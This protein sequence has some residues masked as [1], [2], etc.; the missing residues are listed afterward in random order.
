LTASSFESRLAEVLG[1]SS[2]EALHA[3]LGAAFEGGEKQ[4]G[5]ARQ[6]LD[7]LFGTAAEGASGDELALCRE[8]R[9]L[10]LA[11]SG[12]LLWEL[13]APE[14]TQA[15]TRQWQAMLWP[16]VAPADPQVEPPEAWRD[17]VH[18]DDRNALRPLLEQRLSAGQTA[19]SAEVRLRDSLGSWRWVLVRG[20][21]DGRGPEGRW[22]RILGTS[23][24]V[25]D[26][27]VWE[28]ALMEAR[29]AA[30]AASRTKGEFLAN[31]SHEIRTPMNGILG[32]TDLALDTPLDPE[33]RDYLQ[34]IKNSAEALLTI[35]NDILDFSKIEAGQL[36]LEAIEFSLAAVVTETAKTL[37]VRTHQKG[38]ELICLVGEEVPG[39]LLGDPARIRQI[40][41]NLIGNA[42][43]FTA[44]G[45]VEIRVEVRG[46]LGPDVMVSLAVRD[47]GVGIPADKLDSIFGAFSQADAS[48]TRKFGGTGLGLAICRCLVDLMHGHLGVRSEPG[49]GSTF[50][51]LLP[52][53]WVADAV[54]PA[55][56]DLQGTRVLVVDDS[57]AQG[58]ILGQ[59]IE[60]WGGQATLV[61]SGA[62]ALEALVRER[63]GRDPYD[64]L[65][66]DSAM[67]DRG[68]FAIPAR[69]ARVTP[70]LS[71]IIMLLPSHTQRN[72]AQRCR[73][74]GLASRLVKPIS[75]EDL[76]E[77][78][79]LARHADGEDGPEEP[80]ELA[81][82]DLPDSLGGTRRHLRILLV[83]DNP[84]NQ[85]VATK[86]LEKA[87]HEVTLACNGEEAIELYENRGSFELIL[88]DVQM[89]V[90]G[91]LEATQA[92]RAREARKSWAAGS[93]SWA[94]PIV[95]MTAHAM[96]GDRLR[97]LEAGM[98]DYV[99]K[100]L[101]PAALF[102]AIAR[103]CGEGP[104]E[105]DEGPDMSL[106]AFS[107][108]GSVADLDGMR[109]LLDDDAGAVAQLV[110]MYFRDLPSQLKALRAHVV[111][112]DM[113]ALSQLAHSIKGGVGVFNAARAAEAARVVEEAAR[114]GDR[115]AA[116]RDVTRLL[117][118]LNLL[119]NALRQG[120]P[121]P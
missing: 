67:G 66:V 91:G 81:P 37:A 31:M 2:P 58:R 71:R 105:A 16:M 50:E 62:E 86:V 113:E 57:E 68:G 100:P 6:A 8:Q 108:P 46:R 27:K 4:R 14:G 120:R 25:T 42:I 92:I 111:E 75:R 88:M 53:R 106:M 51:V 89:P 77:A 7:A 83:E 112:G 56:L 22:R 12:A 19:F 101:R 115:A 72:D 26:R 20:R 18:P 84:V 85:T 13:S 29:D 76:R 59:W 1:I 117:Q 54:H 97:C 52:L 82:I 49:V 17:L 96:E 80:F 78:L 47:T 73:E 55:S 104:G 60:A 65:L 63:D 10:A 30:E 24:D 15:F 70:W 61:Q 9:D 116:E 103:V 36:N 33:Q 119:A 3:W 34:T 114:N 5:K 93:G 44:A 40:L 35:V 110:E 87:G 102:A 21:G 98:D 43:K 64:F 99:T 79:Y 28:L 90:M 41:F 95:A 94:V 11:D 45:E 109:E 74:L 23:R 69:Y 121:V 39:V 32:M 107:D 118:E 48:I 38:L